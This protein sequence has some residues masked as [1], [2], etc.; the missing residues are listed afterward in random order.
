[1]DRYDGALGEIGVDQPQAVRR[2]DEDGGRPDGGNGP[3]Q[4]AVGEHGLVVERIHDGDVALH[5]HENG[6]Q[7]ARVGRDP[8]ENREAGGDHVPAARVVEQP[9]AQEIAVVPDQRE[10]GREV[11]Q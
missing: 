2:R 11:R 7:H 1:V 6:V 3:L 5:R 4:S 10:T 9:D 8:N